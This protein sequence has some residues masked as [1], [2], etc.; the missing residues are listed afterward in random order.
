[1]DIS[2]P[3]R[4]L[5]G[6]TGL[7]QLMKKQYALSCLPKNSEKAVTVKH[8]TSLPLFE[9]KKKLNVK[10]SFMSFIVAIYFHL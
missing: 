4:L 1:M 7:L 8:T 6:L 5:T 10:L 9:R 2:G 3:L